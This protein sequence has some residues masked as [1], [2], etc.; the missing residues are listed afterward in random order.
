MTV[1]NDG[2]NATSDDN[3][4]VIEVLITHDQLVGDAPTEPGSTQAM[5]ATVVADGRARTIVRASTGDV[6]MIELW[7][8][9]PMTVAHAV[10]GE[11]DQPSPTGL[12][13]D[14]AGASMVLDL[15]TIHADSSVAASAAGSVSG[16]V[17][18]LLDRATDAN[19]DVDELLVLSDTSTAPNARVAAAV[20][21]GTLYWGRGSGD[22][23]I[24]LEPGNPASLVAAFI[25]LLA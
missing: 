22:D 17:R 7:V 21:G 14:G 19:G 5:V 24:R 13:T 2:T 23:E 3:G 20:C 15:L 4:T 25:E 12:A 16:S 9:G 10:N 1:S 18:D 6:R 8:A 11:P